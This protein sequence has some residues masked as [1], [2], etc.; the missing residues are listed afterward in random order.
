MDPL[1][2]MLGDHGHG[3]LATLKADGRPQL[4]TIDFCYDA[5]ARVARISTLDGSAKVAN[6]RRDPRASLYVGSADLSSYAVAEG[7]VEISATAAAADDA[8]VEELVDVYRRIQGEH[9]DW[10]D[11]R[12]AMVEQRRVVV[13][14]AVTRFYGLKR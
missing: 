6:L 13:R 10:D 7:E 4:A 12:A 5:G 1:E 11:Y 2:S 8:T 3:V 14:L 9:P